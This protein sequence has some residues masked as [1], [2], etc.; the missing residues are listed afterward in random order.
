MRATKIL[1]LSGILAG[2]A[3]LS[4]PASN[5]AHAQGFYIDAPGV[6]VGVGHRHHRSYR[7]YDYRDYGY[8]RGY[9]AYGYDQARPYGYRH[10]YGSAG[11][12]F[13]YTVQ[14]GVCKPYTGR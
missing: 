3:A 13:N 12:P 4:V 6:H 14:D 1:L 7:D 10:N 11:C 8:R 5:A 9:R 2:A